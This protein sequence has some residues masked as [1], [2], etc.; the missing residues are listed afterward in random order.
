MRLALDL[1]AAQVAYPGGAG[2][3]PVARKLLDFTVEI[4]RARGGDALFVLLNGD[5]HGTVEPIRDALAGILPAENI[6][7]WF[8]LAGPGGDRDPARCKAAGLIREAA[9]AALRP[10]A[11]HLFGGARADTAGAV[12]YFG[13]FAKAIPFS[14]TLHAL[15]QGGDAPGNMPGDALDWATLR[16]AAHVQAPA[17]LV[18]VLIDRGLPAAR[19]CPLPED[20]AAFWHAARTLPAAITALATRTSAPARR[21]LAYVSPL[22]PVRTGIADYSA[23]LLPELARYYDITLITVQDEP[24]LPPELGL[25]VQDATWLRANAHRFD[26]VLYHIGNAPFHGYMLALLEAIPGTVVLHDFMLGHM[27]A[28][29]E[30]NAI[31]PG[32]WAQSLYHS[33]GYAA[34]SERYRDRM[35]PDFIL[36]YPANLAVLEH[37]DGIIS[38]SRYARELSARW[39]GERFSQDWRVVPLLRAPPAA[40]DRAASRAALGLDADGIIVCSFGFIGESKLSQRLLSAWLASDLAR[41]ERCLLIFVG[42]NPPAAYGRELAGSIQASGV[43]HRIRITGWT[44]TAAYRHYLSAADMGVQLRSAS[45]GETSAAVGDCLNY[46]LATIINANG[47]MAELPH[48]AAWQLPDRFRDSELVEAL[49]TLWRDAGRRQALAERG[50]T[51]IA[52]QHAPAVCAAQYEAAI[53]AFAARART[54]APALLRALAGLPEDPPDDAECRRLAACVAASLAPAGPPRRLF[55]DVSNTCRT[56]LNSGIE[57]VARGLAVALLEAPPDGFRVEPVYLALED[58]AWRY[59]HACR[60]TLELL[61]IWGRPLADEIVE[62]RAGDVLLGLDLA[63]Q[64]LPEQEAAGLIRQFREAGAAVHFVVYD[65]LPVLLPQFFPPAS[66]GLH[67]GWLRLVAQA[68]GALCISQEV[69]DEYRDWLRRQQVATRRDFQIGWFHLGA[70]LENSAPSSG[71]PARAERLLATLGNRPCFLMV[72]TIEP[73]K[74]YLQALD[75]FTELWAQGHDINLVIVGR[76]GWKHVPAQDRRTIPEIVARLR[77]HPELGRRLFWLDSASDELLNRLYAVSNCLIAASEGEG[78]GLPLIEAA[79]QNV[80]ILARDIPVFREVAGAGAYYFSGLAGEDLAAA[81][82]GWLA[83]QAGGRH[84]MPGELRWT[85]WQESAAQLL[86]AMLGQVPAQVAL[87]SAAD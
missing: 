75:A 19:I 31:L 18:P 85:T 14:V 71:L 57:R 48:D 39:Y 58:G 70:D 41:D 47:A 67:A 38:H 76:E 20:A 44:D 9:L 23:D 1:Q 86:Q 51:L 3:Q 80:P 36:R 29:L 66:A 78:F 77:G 24:P 11:V 61:N 64:G 79:R 72:G 33:H 62:P 32:I 56:E 17:A 15:P 54:G 12:A 87:A 60:Y 5:L 46:G 8:A 4:A 73:R 28:Y 83:L 27:L 53:E 40:V 13:G 43:G 16:A 2:L 50:R 6:R 45:R 22:P 30:E 52:T 25:D 68:D 55:L 74:G 82:A 42:E 26:R 69:A 49:E 35:M 65:L 81:V 34:L 21:R 84:P 7:L 63:Y 37:A 59:R 10:D